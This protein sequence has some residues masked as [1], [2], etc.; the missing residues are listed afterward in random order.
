MYAVLAPVLQVHR[1][2][3][4]KAVFELLQELSPQ[5]QI[6]LVPHDDAVPSGL[7]GTCPPK[8]QALQPIGQGAELTLRQAAAQRDRLAV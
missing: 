3:R 5:R 8:P 2:A 1:R 4:R 6:I 7:R